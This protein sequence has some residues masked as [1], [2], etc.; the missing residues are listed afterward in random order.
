MK[1]GGVAEDREPAGEG[2]NV[3]PIGLEKMHDASFWGSVK[4]YVH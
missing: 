1:A 2:V 4:L 3:W